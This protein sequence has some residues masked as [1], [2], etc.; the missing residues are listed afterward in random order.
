ME[1][2]H[3][4]YFGALACAWV[5]G[6]LCCLGVASWRARWKRKVPA[7]DQAHQD[8]YGGLAKSKDLFSLGAVRKRFVKPK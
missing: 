7:I 4:M 6:Y 2:N 5:S 3:T 8:F 1:F